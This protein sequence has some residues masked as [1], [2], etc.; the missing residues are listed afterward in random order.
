M[1]VGLTRAQILSQ[2]A[3]GNSVNIGGVQYT[4]ANA[5]SV[6]S[7][8][9]LQAI[10]AAAALRND[11]SPDSRF[12]I[13]FR[14]PTSADGNMNDAWLDISAS[15]PWLYLKA[16]PTAW[17]SY[18]QFPAAP[19]PGPTNLYEL[20]DVNLSGASQDMALTYQQNSNDWRARAVLTFVNDWGI[21]NGNDVTQGTVVLYDSKFWFA[22]TSGNANTTPDLD[23]ILWAQIQ[24]GAAVG[25]GG[26]AVR[27]VYDPGIDYVIDDVV[28]HLGVYYVALQASTG[29]SPTH[30]PRDY[31]YPLSGLFSGM[32]DVNITAPVDGDIPIWSGGAGTWVNG[33]I[34]PVFPRL[35]FAGYFTLSSGVANITV[36]TM[37]GSN[38]VFATFSEAPT[39]TDELYTAVTSAT[40]IRISSRDAASTKSGNWQVIK[41]A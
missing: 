36:P 40:T 18:Y 22:I 17:G 8:A 16:T 27:G 14:P 41:L 21:V 33:T 11:P 39:A 5:T 35:L 28:Y 32:A 25:G 26:W 3:A 15:P 19:I 2:L 13:D 37:T 9:Q 7:D 12:Y 24:L 6:P 23:P 1:T 20:S 29:Q 10:Y 34:P 4:Q 38:I 31:W 30:L